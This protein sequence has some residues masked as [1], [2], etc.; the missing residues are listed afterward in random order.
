M[1]I[2]LDLFF[3]LRAGLHKV[4]VNEDR[5]SITADFTFAV[6]GKNPIV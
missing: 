6:S 3:S 2:G 1:S 5:Y 4:K